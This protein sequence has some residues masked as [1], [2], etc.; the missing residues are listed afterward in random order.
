MAMEQQRSKIIFK[1]I[2]MAAYSIRKENGRIKE[3]M[4][5]KQDRIHG[6]N[7]TN[8]K[9]TL[10]PNSDIP[11]PTDLPRQQCQFRQEPS[12]YGLACRQNHFFQM[13]YIVHRIRKPQRPVKGYPRACRPRDSGFPQ[14][15]RVRIRDNGLDYTGL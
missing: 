7:S 10:Q 15:L 12:L 14:H 1:K 2:N 5:R 13:W 4:K 8:P 6:N 11:T 9:P 3:N